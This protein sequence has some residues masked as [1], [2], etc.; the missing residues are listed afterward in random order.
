MC[1]V[2]ECTQG[3]T[4]QSTNQISRQSCPELYHGWFV[5]TTSL[6]PSQKCQ[7]QSGLPSQNEK[8]YA[9]LRAAVA[10]NFCLSCK[11]YTEPISPARS[12]QAQ[13]ALCACPACNPISFTG[14]GQTT[15]TFRLIWI[16]KTKQASAKPQS[17]A[18]C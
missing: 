1:P 15:K 9:C 14:Q 18:A 7:N 4:K 8:S 13:R 16:P 3:I 17:L 5:A 12:V 6:S 2:I 10:T 11:A